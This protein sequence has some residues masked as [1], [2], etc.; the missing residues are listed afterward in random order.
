MF[1]FSQVFFIFKYITVVFKVDINDSLQCYS[2]LILY[3]NHGPLPATVTFPA[4]G[5]KKK[6]QTP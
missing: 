2:G 1:V 3:I 6:Q 4:K 5:K